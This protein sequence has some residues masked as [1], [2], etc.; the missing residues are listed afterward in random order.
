LSHTG[1]PAPQL[2]LPSRAHV[3]THTARA[4][5]DAARA[6]LA[7][8]GAIQSIARRTGFG[9]PERMRRA[10]VRVYGAPPAALRRT[11]RPA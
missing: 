9:V 4:E 1:T 8:G 7:Q 3:E 11:L 2:A 5:A 10:F 6:A